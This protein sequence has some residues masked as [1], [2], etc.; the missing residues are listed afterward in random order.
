MK[1]IS[2]IS[3][4]IFSVGVLLSLFAGALTLVGFIAAIFVGGE[5][6]THMCV[7]IH[8]TLFP[9]VIKFTTV[10]VALGLLG[11]YLSKVKALTVSDN[12]SEEK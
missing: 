3:L 2:N 5:T 8:K 9:Y 4:K 10:F 1:K 12:S 6:A 11:M 7:F